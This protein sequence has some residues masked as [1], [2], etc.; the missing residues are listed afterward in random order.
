MLDGDQ[1]YP[2]MLAAIQSARHLIVIEQYLVK[3][4]AV[5]DQF[6]GVLASAV[7][8]GVC[9][10]M[11]LD[12]YGSRG[13]AI[14]D[15]K[16]IQDAGIELHFYNP[17]RLSQ[18]IKSLFRNHRKMLLVDGSVVF[19]GGA[20]ISDEFFYPQKA[21]QNSPWR[22]VVLEIK[23]KV[24][25]DWIDLFQHTLSHTSA[26]ELK[27]NWQAVQ[28]SCREQQENQQAQVLIASALGRQEISRAFL[29]H[30]QRARSRVWLS[31]PYFV[32][33]RKIRRALRAAAHRQVDVRLLLPGGYSDHPWVTYASQ[34]F[35]Q[36]LLNAGVKLFE[37]QPGFSHSK[38][39]LVDDWVS[40]G[41]CN[42]D[43]WNMHW[44]LE[45]NQSVLSKQFAAQVAQRLEADF[46][47]CQQVT[48]QDWA[49]R[50]LL[51]RGK[52]WVSTLLVRIIEKVFGRF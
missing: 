52:S 22:D 8:R 49:Q 7:Q 51:Q 1:F 18:A 32:T 29:S 47:Q 17:V 45:A 42:L 12:D 34:R 3:S 26:N 6:I 15:R 50:S 4:G 5:L 28:N 39:Q 37:F 40:I 20:G 46:A 9:V 19:V 11:L 25:R 23:G 36:K 30:V 14:S 24:L 13:L 16:R 10:I 44:N 35:Y 43:R 33:T 27:V 48:L 38:I 2:R 41:S 21:Y 31:T